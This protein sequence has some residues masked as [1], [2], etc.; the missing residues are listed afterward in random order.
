MLLMRVNPLRGQVGG[1]LA[2]KIDTFLGSV[3]WHRAVKRIGAQISRDFQGPSNG[4][5]QIESIMYGAVS[6]RVLSP[7]F[8]E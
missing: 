1:G 3:K 4:F 5:A 2:L 8:D 7:R 6:I